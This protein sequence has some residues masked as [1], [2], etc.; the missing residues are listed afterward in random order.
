[1]LKKKA[2]SRIEEYSPL[3]LFIHYPPTFIIPTTHRQTDRQTHKP[4]F[5]IFLFCHLRL[6]RARWAAKPTPPDQA[7]FNQQHA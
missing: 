4:H 6:S 2:S 3:F 1:M 7:F 5:F